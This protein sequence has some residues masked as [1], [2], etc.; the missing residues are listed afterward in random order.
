MNYLNIYNALMLKRKEN[1]S[2]AGY[3]ENHHIVP[4]CMGGEDSKDNMVALSAKEHYVAHHLLYKHYKNTK[5]AHAW[6]SM[7]RSSSNQERSFT[8]KM[9]ERAMNARSEEMRESS[10]GP[11]NNFFGR[12]HTEETKRK[13][14]EANRGESRSKEQIVAW[15]ETIAKKPKSVEHRA[16]IARKGLIM[17]KNVDTLEIVR[18]SHAEA[19]QLNGTWV[20]PRTI[21]PES[22]YKCDHCDV[23]TNRGNLKRW[24][25]EN[26]KNIVQLTASE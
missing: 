5:L 7:L 11:G 24:H 19:A 20:N 22:K 3:I 8:A 9:R 25:N 10:K 14:G 23:E 26:C 4:V 2:A 13:I 16:K 12:K 21:T 15:I 6:F 1:P 18:V 17:L